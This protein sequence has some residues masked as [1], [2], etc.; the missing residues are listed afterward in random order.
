VD[1]GTDKSGRE[2]ILGLVVYDLK[3]HNAIQWIKRLELRTKRSW[4]MTTPH[5]GAKDE[6]IAPVAPFA[7]QGFEIL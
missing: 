4:R 5:Q 7:T 1:L 2:C 3:H 6:C